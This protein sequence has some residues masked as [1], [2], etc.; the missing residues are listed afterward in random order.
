M[1]WWEAR[2]HGAERISMTISILKIG[3]TVLGHPISV[4][5][6]G[7]KDPTRDILILGG[8]HGNECEGVELARNS[9]QFLK[10]ISKDII[11]NVHVIPILNID[12]YFLGLRSNANDVDLNRNVPTNNWKAEFENPRYKPGVEAAS[13]PETKAL[14]SFVKTLNLELIISLHSYEKSLLLV[15][16]GKKDFRKLFS[17]LGNSLEI[18]VVDKMEYP[19]TGSLNTFSRD[20]D[21]SC[22]TI[23]APRGD[24]WGR[25]ASSFT[26]DY[27][28]FV[29]EVVTSA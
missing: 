20:Q 21:L 12:G 2:F 3:D 11:P 7:G 8:V 26:K 13:E 4:W 15:N 1:V 10:S 16:N 19:V 29:N 14:M 24:V 6:F 22:L 9:L 27:L 23:E 25:V 5:S 18:P 28:A 17:N